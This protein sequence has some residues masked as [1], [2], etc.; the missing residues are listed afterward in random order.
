MLKYEFYCIRNEV[1]VARGSGAKN[2]GE[3]R[4]RRRESVPSDDRSIARCKKLQKVR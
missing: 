1:G 3:E 4:G 2:S